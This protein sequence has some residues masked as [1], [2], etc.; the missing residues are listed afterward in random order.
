MA[1]LLLL[2]SAIYESL[3]VKVEHLPLRVWVFGLELN[4]IFI[5]VVS[6]LLFEVRQHGGDRYQMIVVVVSSFPSYEYLFQQQSTF[7]LQSY[8]LLAEQ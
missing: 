2:I 5:H 1:I 3:C 4:L 8:E 6:I 7:K